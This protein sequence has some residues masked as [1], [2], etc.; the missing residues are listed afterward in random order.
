MI[1]NLFCKEEMKDSLEISNIF[2]KGKKYEFINGRNPR[3]TEA[4]GYVLKDDLGCKR[5]LDQK[6]K[7]KHFIE[8]D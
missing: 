2:T 5:W 1:V 7:E 4:I 3:D 6:I 8:G